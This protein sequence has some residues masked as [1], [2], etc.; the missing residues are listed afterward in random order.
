MK[1]I[2]FVLMLLIFNGVYAGEYTNELTG[3]FLPSKWS[4]ETNGLVA[5]L[6]TNMKEIQIGT[7]SPKFLLELKNVSKQ[8]V[9]INNTLS[10]HMLL[11]IKP[12]KVDFTNYDLQWVLDE[13]RRRTPLKP[14]ETVRAVLKLPMK[15]VPTAGKYE[16]SMQ[17]SRG[18]YPKNVRG[19]IPRDPKW[20][21][22]IL[23]LP[24][25]EIEYK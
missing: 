24:P 1:K 16:F 9:Y 10:S 13:D 7:G 25:V 17:I 19:V 20:W 14:N 2:V 3:T 23:I 18:V 21:T 4:T 8:D 5:R 22:G 6:C 11:L 12:H 15:L